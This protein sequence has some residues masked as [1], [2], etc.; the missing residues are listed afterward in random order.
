MVWDMAQRKSISQSLRWTVFSRD[1]F[2]CRYCGAQAG[3]NGVELHIDHVVS[4]ADG[5]DN[6]ID[7][8]VTA[9]AGCNGGKSARS[10]KGAPTSLEVIEK[11]K[12]RAKAMKAQASAVKA[13]IRAEAELRLLVHQI[14]DTAYGYA[15]CQ[16]DAAEES[17]AI[18]LCREFGPEKVSEWY[19]SA[20]RHNVSEWKAVRYISGCARNERERLRQLAGEEED[21]DCAI[22]SLQESVHRWQSHC[23]MLMTGR[24]DAK[25][26]SDLAREMLDWVSG[27]ESTSDNAKEKWKP[28]RA[29]LTALLI[30]SES[31]EAA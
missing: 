25:R 17:R 9:C 2:T 12:D 29:T 30:G 11:M 23:F 26:K 20:C 21:A 7:N 19:A 24:A 28:I 31:T 16:M 14:K 3:Q 1:N 22:K 13:S 8:L 15:E 10:L 27:W 5:G 4:V 18:T 6:S